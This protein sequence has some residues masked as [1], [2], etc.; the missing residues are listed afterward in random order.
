MVQ[1]EQVKDPI[2][3]MQD[4]ANPWEW[5]Y[6]KSTLDLVNRLKLVEGWFKK[7]SAGPVSKIMA[8]YQGWPGMASLLWAHLLGIFSINI[9]F[10]VQVSTG[11]RYCLWRGLCSCSAVPSKTVTNGSA[12]WWLPSTHIQELSH[13]LELFFCWRTETLEENG[14][15]SS[16]KT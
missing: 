1:R 7:D 4:Y 15:R 9:A 11:L 16:R 8:A 2:E 10:K 14:L 13:G 12:G 5:N 3:R 6:R